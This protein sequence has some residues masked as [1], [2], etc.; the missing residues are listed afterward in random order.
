MKFTIF[1]IKPIIKKNLFKINLIAFPFELK[2]NF[3]S[4][5]NVDY[6]KL[7]LGLIF[8]KLGSHEDLYIKSTRDVNAEK[9][10]NFSRDM[11][12]ELVLY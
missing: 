5:I 7:E 12:L 4:N 11:G 3:F 1:P 6:S 8:L 10:V 9:F 2:N